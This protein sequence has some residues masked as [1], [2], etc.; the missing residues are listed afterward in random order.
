MHL[1]HFFLKT[2]LWKT[3]HSPHVAGKELK[4]GLG[5]M[6]LWA[7]HVA[8]ISL[9]FLTLNLIPPP[10]FFFNIAESLGAT[11]LSP[12]HPQLP[13]QLPVI[14]LPSELFSYQGNMKKWFVDSPQSSCS[15]TA[16]IA[17]VMFLPERSGF[18]QWY[19]LGHQETS[20][21]SLPT[22]PLREGDKAAPSLQVRAPCWSSH[23]WPVLAAHAVPAALF[24]AK[25][26]V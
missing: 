11:I 15:F 5:D 26:P 25:V 6:R 9:I 4:C 20:W 18:L 7:V 2:V 22:K 16:V 24:L 12:I 3:S 10:F 13:C 21:L 14:S 23:A 8:E 19:L 1:C 17:V